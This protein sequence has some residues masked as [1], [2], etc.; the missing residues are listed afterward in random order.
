MMDVRRYFVIGSWYAIIRN[1][2]KKREVVVLIPCYNEE[3]TIAKV[4]KDFLDELPGAKI[5]VFDNSDKEPFNNTHDN[6]TVFAKKKKNALDPSV[7]RAL[8]IRN[9]ADYMDYFEQLVYILDY[10]LDN[11]S[12]DLFVLLLHLNNPLIIYT[13]LY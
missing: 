5:F 6:V 1:M 11:K 7:E 12:L 3:K 13:Y 9:L 8:R 4:V 10:I 2:T